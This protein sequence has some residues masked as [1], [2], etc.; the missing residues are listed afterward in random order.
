MGITQW[1]IVV[2]VFSLLLYPVMQL[3]PSEKQK[4]QVTFRQ[5]AMRLG[6]R[7]QVRHPNLPANFLGEHPELL[8][9]IGCHLPVKESSLTDRFTAI[10]KNS[11]GEWEW[12]GYS[13]PPESIRLPLLALSASIPAPALAL[14]IAPGGASL[15]VDDTH[16]MATAEETAALLAQLNQVITG[17]Y[18]IR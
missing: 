13:L 7:L 14:E 9:T 15:F 6:I 17:F 4:R 8:R 2:I 16:P 1:V 11:S 10:R 3:I 5:A 18:T 12:I